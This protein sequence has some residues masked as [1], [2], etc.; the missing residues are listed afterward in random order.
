MSYIKF[1]KTKKDHFILIPKEIDITKEQEKS[2]W[3]DVL[4][5]IDNEINN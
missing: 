2:V 3:R 1:K 5:I 4:G